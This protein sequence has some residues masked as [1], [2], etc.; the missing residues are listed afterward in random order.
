MAFYG[1]VGGAMGNVAAGDS[2]FVHREARNLVRAGVEWPAN[3]RKVPRAS[4]RWM[5][6]VWSDFLSR[7]SSESYQNFLDPELRDW[8]HAYYGSNYNR[9]VAVK[10]QVD[11]ANRFRFRQSIRG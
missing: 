6:R 3:R 2:A 7:Q 1:W 10:R 5:Q 4:R 8:Q 9:L 11:P